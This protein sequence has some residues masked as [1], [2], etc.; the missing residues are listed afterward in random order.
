MDPSVPSV[1]PVVEP[2]APEPVRASRRPTTW[3]RLARLIALAM[4]V[5]ILTVVYW[6][7]FQLVGAWG[8]AA[9]LAILT[10]SVVSMAS[11]M[12]ALRRRVEALESRNAPEDQK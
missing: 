11:R 12:W 1:E 7:P 8:A 2:P 10:L 6:V 5:V 9:V 4:L 3:D